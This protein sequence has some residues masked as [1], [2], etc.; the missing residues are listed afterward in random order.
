MNM[1]KHGL[2]PFLGPLGMQVS[3]AKRVDASQYSSCDKLV[4]A[5]A[6]D[7]ATQECAPS[8]ARPLQAGQA[9]VSLLCLLA[10]L[11]AMAKAINSAVRGPGQRPGSVLLSM[12]ALVKLGGREA[13]QAAM[14]SLGIVL[15]APGLHDDLGFEHGQ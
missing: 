12:P 2:T 7:R 4:F 10:A 11:P 8:A 3:P 15:A 1:S 14:R 6:E 13:V 9:L 5:D